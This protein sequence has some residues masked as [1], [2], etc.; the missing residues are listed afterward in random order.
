MIPNDTSM[1][2]LSAYT[3]L[4]MTRCNFV[5][6]VLCHLFALLLLLHLQLQVFLCLFQKQVPIPEKQIHQIH[7]NYQLTTQLPGVIVKWSY[8][9]RTTVRCLAS[10]PA[11]HGACL[12][13]SESSAKTGPLQREHTPVEHK[14]I[15]IIFCYHRLSS[16]FPVLSIRVVGSSAPA[17][18]IKHSASDKSRNISV[19]FTLAWQSAPTPRNFCS[20]S[21]KARRCFCSVFCNSAWR[22]W[23]AYWGP[24]H[25]WS[26]MT[27]YVYNRI[28]MM[29]INVFTYV[30]RRTLRSSR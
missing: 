2:P 9:N 24:Q 19:D 6:E 14:Y 5:L 25:I 3:S 18:S 27:V 4:C 1:Q 28:F 13:P 12:R 26:Y 21:F 16:F 23:A 15:E 8:K 7:P 10:L 17:F 22:P 20:E 29:Y 11:L 30:R